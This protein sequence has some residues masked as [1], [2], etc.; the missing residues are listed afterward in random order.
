MLLSGFFLGPLFGPENGGSM[1]LRM[2]WLFT[3]N[4]ALQPLTATAE[5]AAGAALCHRQM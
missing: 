4:T 1:F 5:A 3:N 2:L